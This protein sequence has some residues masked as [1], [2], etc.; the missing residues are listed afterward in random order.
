[1]RGGLPKIENKR[2]DVFNRFVRDDDDSKAKTDDGSTGSVSSEDSD[3]YVPGLLD[4]PEMVRTGSSVTGP[5][6]SSSIQ[7]VKPAV[8]KADCSYFRVAMTCTAVGR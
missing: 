4:D 7:F 3:V 6:V 1:V 5:I 2:D 8:L